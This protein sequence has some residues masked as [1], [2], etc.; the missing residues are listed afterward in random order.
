MPDEALRWMLTILL[1]ACV[2]WSIWMTLRLA[3]LLRMHEHPE[4]T[5]FG[6]VGFRE[7]I[8]NNTRAMRELVHYVKW[9]AEAQTGTKAP[10][11][12]DLDT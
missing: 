12:V 7:T 5:G 8:S 1:P 11:F 9:L 4:D 10:P 6:T 2:P 3:K